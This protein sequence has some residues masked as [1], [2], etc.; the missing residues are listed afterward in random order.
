MEF[1]AMS[2]A[3]PM[4]TLYYGDDLATFGHYLVS[5]VVIGKPNVVAEVAADKIIRY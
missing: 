3:F 5:E 2:S 4:K 1:R